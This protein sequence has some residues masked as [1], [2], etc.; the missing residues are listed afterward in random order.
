M[1][2]DKS[3]VLCGFMGC[4]KSTVGK[5]LAKTKSYNVVDL[6]DYIEKEQN[7]SISKIFE[8]YGEQY[9]R[10]LEHNA[11]KKLSAEKNIVISA[12]GGTL[13]FE[14][15]V[16]VCR[17]NSIVIYLQV[18]LKSIK[19][20]LK[21]DTKRPLLQKPN[22]DEI[23]QEMYNARNPLYE[24]A[25]QFVVDGNKLPKDVVADIEKIIASL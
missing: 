24:K 11:I 15:N 25:S 20:R 2:N 8:L 17:Q 5:L 10:D 1:T 3:I 22:K 12:G 14:R 18:S 21:N 4:G 7:M 23:M 13:V 6:D 16:E 9:F 19:K